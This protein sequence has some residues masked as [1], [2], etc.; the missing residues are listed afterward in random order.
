MK[1]TDSVCQFI[2]GAWRRG[3]ELESLRVSR[4]TIKVI[5]IENGVLDDIN[6]PSHKTLMGVKLVVSEDE[7]CTAPPYTPVM[8]RARHAAAWGERLR[9]G[10]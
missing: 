7:L 2:L 1:V 5:R 3:E 4:E 10:I 6:E 9:K 8:R